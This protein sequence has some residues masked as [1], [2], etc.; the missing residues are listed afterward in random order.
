MVVFLMSFRYMCMT[1]VMCCLCFPVSIGV[2]QLLEASQ[3][4]CLRPWTKA[5]PM[6]QTYRSQVFFYRALR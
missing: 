4:C 1:S 6:P 3:V 5:N 2:Q